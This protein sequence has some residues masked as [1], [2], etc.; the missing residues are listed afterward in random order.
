MK[1]LKIFESYNWDLLPDVKIGDYVSID[2]S[3]LSKFMIDY[4]VELYIDFLNNNIGKIININ[5]VVDNNSF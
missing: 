3:E 2:A 4:N 1:Y 5:R